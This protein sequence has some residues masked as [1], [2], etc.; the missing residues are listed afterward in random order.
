MAVCASKCYNLCVLFSCLC[1]DRFWCF[2]SVL[3]FESHEFS[4]PGI[5]SPVFALIGS[6]GHIKRL[7]WF[8]VPG[9]MAILFGTQRLLQYKK[10]AVCHRLVMILTIVIK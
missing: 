10:G 7:L 3:V 8:I 4:A 5:L 9:M 6:T 1:R 2:F